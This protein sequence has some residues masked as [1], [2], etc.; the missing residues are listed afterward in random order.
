MYI[1][2]KNIPVHQNVYSSYL[3][4]LFILEYNTAMS[5]TKE[6]KNNPDEKY[7]KLANPITYVQ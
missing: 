3:V 6:R 4:P 2:R 1:D 7:I 5:N